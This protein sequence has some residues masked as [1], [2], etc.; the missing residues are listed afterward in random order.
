MR[1]SEFEAEGA[2]GIRLEG[3]DVREAVVKEVGAEFGLGDGEG[4][5]ERE[6]ETALTDVGGRKEQVDEAVTAATEPSS[7]GSGQMSEDPQGIVGD[8]LGG[9]GYLGEKL[10]LDGIVRTRRSE[11]PNIARMNTR[12]EYPN[13]I[14][15]TA[16]IHKR[17]V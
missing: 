12:A 9:G 2:Y 4:Y 14:F 15:H 5:D 6:Q 1:P 16:K 7:V 8:A 11:R 17:R 10:L 3:I 13:Q